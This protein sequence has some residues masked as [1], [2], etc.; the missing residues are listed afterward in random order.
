MQQ[1]AKNELYWK[2]KSADT[3]LFEKYTDHIRRCIAS[4]YRSVGRSYS[5]NEIDEVFQEAA[6]KIIRNGYAL[7]HDALR[8]SM[9]TWLGLIAR[10]TAIDHLRKSRETVDLDVELLAVDEDFD[11]ALEPLPIPPGVL[12]DRQREVLD[13]YFCEGLEA[14]E[15]GERLGIEPRTARSIKHQALKR[16][17]RRMRLDA[18]FNERINS[19]RRFS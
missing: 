13:L 14:A 5:Q 10:T 7:R 2:T 3:A 16:L 18:G 1:I 8:S 4:F 6:C 11:A 17:R 15:I 9:P 12:T 19:G